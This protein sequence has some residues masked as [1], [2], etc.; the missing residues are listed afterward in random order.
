MKN[1][2]IRSVIIDF[3]YNDTL[4]YFLINDINGETYVK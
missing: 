3:F 4:K 1:S 2:V